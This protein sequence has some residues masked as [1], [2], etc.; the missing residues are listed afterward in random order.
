M[1]SV[2]EPEVKRLKVAKMQSIFWGEESES[3]K[4]NRIFKSVDN[5]KKSEP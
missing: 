5:L 3:S 2:E 4:K 1:R